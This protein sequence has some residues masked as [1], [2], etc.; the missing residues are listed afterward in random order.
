M[1]YA[2]VALAF[3]GAT[4]AYFAVG[5]ALFAALPGMKREFQK[6]PGV[7][8]TEDGMKKLMPFA[9]ISIFISIAIVAVLFATIYP[10]GG[11]VVSGVYLGALLGIFAVCVFVI[12]NYVYLNIGVTLAMYEGVTYFIQWIIVGAVIALIYKP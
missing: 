6:Y 12:H 5:F 1:N 10:A 9:M 11:G 8:R 4:V 2:H 3:L 7:F